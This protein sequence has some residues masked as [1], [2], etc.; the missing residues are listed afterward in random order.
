MQCCQA[1][2]IF[3]HW[4]SIAAVSTT[5]PPRIEAVSTTGPPR[6][7]SVSAASPPKDEAEGV[8]LLAVHANRA[9]RIAHSWKKRQG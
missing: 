3:L 9:G 4:M 8:G 5:S 7:K 2:S 6:D 1:G